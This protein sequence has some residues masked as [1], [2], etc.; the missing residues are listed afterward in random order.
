MRIFNPFKYIKTYFIISTVLF[1]FALNSLEAKT[2]TN[3]SDQLK[4]EHIISGK[5]T[6]KI[7]E[8]KQI[9]A[10]LLAIKYPK[11]PAD[12]S[13]PQLWKTAID[14][15]WT[16]DLLPQLDI[17]MF[18]ESRCNK[19][20]H[21][22]SDPMGGSYGLA[23]INGYWCRSTQYNPSGWLQAQKILKSCEDLYKPIV[24]LRAAKAIYDYGVDKHGY[25]WGPWSTKRY[26]K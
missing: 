24:N 8:Q 22:P 26:L 7:L 12:A 19:M 21:N 11:P 18:R 25:G 6:A 10:Y 14:A 16:K 20:S 13:C 2:E 3:D 15:G 4:I 5:K 17:I 1:F 9:D 23:Q